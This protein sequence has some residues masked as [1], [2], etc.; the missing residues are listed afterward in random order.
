ML[1]FVMQVLMYSTAL[2][3]RL[4]AAVVQVPHSH[5]QN[6]S[7]GVTQHLPPKQQLWCARRPAGAAAGGRGG[8]TAGGRA[9]QRKD[10]LERRMRVRRHVLHCRSHHAPGQ[11]PH[12]IHVIVF[13]ISCFLQDVCKQDQVEWHDNGIF[14]M[15]T[16]CGA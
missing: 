4:G 16:S 12:L 11:P 2:L 1:T 3:K 7:E 13:L 14:A 15:S 10:L 8:D 5:L 9:L 6:L